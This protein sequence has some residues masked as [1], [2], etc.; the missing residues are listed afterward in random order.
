MRNKPLQVVHIGS[1]DWWV[2]V[3][4]S[5]HLL[6]LSLLWRSL[7]VQ[8][9]N[10]AEDFLELSHPVGQPKMT[11]PSTI[12]STP[13]N[14]QCRGNTMSSSSIL[15]PSSS[16]S[17]WTTHSPTHTLS[18]IQVITRKPAKI[19]S[20]CAPA[21]ELSDLCVSAPSRICIDNQQD[22]VTWQCC[23]GHGDWLV[24]VGLSLSVW[25]VLY[26]ISLLILFRLPE[27]FCSFR[28]WY[29]IWHFLQTLNIIVFDNCECSMIIIWH[30]LICLAP[31]I[32]QWNRLEL[33]IYFVLPVDLDFL[34]PIYEIFHAI[35]QP[36]NFL[37]SSNK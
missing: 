16:T 7:I 28:F 19:T 3:V 21:K 5:L 8:W 37:L 10:I 32:L 23:Y 17:H 13:N 9:H 2:S 35:V 24:I 33:K 29:S 30:I 1:R 27:Q 18:P 22:K 25:E 4:F 20:Q 31:N 11:C 12:T 36:N 14:G 6:L 34:V 26:W 15:P